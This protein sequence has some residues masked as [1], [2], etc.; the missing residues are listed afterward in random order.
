MPAA[1]RVVDEANRQAG[2][3]RRRLGAEVRQARLAAGLSQRRVADALRCSSS[4]VSRVERGLVRDLT[5]RQ[6]ALQAAVVGMAFRANVYPRG[7]PIRDAGQLRVLN[8]LSPHVRAPFRWAIELPVGPD[9]LRAFDAGAIQPGC[10]VAFDV[11]SRV[12]DA[13][14]QARAS[15][16]KQL[17]AQCDRLILVFGD[18][19]ANR[20]SVSDSGVALRRAFPLTSRQVLAALRAGRDPGGNGIVFI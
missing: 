11:W 8:R 20:R 17:D 2:D 12:R 7:S 16:R 14:A 6:I 15:L 9:D 10:R 4:T 18:T 1:V 5:V 19:E 13:Q 3:T